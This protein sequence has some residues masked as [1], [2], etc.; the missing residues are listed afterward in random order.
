MEKTFSDY[1][2]EYAER[3][4]S[5]IN[6]DKTPLGDTMIAF[7]VESAKLAN[8]NERMMKA[9]VQM[10]ERLIDKEPI[11]MITENDFVEEEGPDGKIRARCTR[12]KHIYRAPDGR[13]YNDRAI[14]FKRK[15]EP[16]NNKQY[17]YQGNLSS[18]Q[19]IFLPY[20][21]SEHIVYLDDLE[22]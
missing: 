6:F 7:L 11:S 3:E 20:Y 19:E 2:V 13:Y 15:G 5:L 14:T 22:Q 9:M 12:H 8:N 4:L 10:L 21:P 16:E 1:L 17:I 18:K